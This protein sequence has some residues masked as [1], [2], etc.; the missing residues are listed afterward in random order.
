MCIKLERLFLRLSHLKVGMFASKFFSAQ[1]LEQIPVPTFVLNKWGK[2]L[3][4]NRACEA[5]TGV[6]SRDVVGTREHWRA[7]YAEARPCLADVILNSQN[8]QLDELYAAESIEL[9]SGGELHAENWC[10]LPN[11]KRVYLAISASPVRD[12]FG[13]IVAVVETLRDLTAERE[14]EAAVAEA[15]RLNDA[16]TEEALVLSQLNDWL[17]SCKTLDELCDMVAQF[18]SKL[19]PSCSGSL[20][21]YAHSRDVL[22]NSI[23]WNGNQGAAAMQPDECWGL[24]RGRPYTY[25][26]QKVDFRCQHIGKHEPDH[27]SCIPILAHGDTVG[28][29]HLE[30]GCGHHKTDAV[31]DTI[32]EQRRIASLCAEQISLAIA[33]VRLRDQLRDQSIRDPL[34]DLFNRRYMLETCRREFARA[35]HEGRSVSALSIDID[36]FKRFNDNHGHDAGDTVLRAVAACLKNNFREEDVPSRFGG[37]EFVV[38]L[39]GAS[40]EIALQRAEELRASIANLSVRYLESNLPKITISVGVAAFPHAGDSPQSVLRAADEALY[41]AKSDG[42][43][44]VQ[45]AGTESEVVEAEP[46]SKKRRTNRKAASPTKRTLCEVGA[47]H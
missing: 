15:L 13:R 16:K 12:S 43:N 1:V 20:Y 4:W 27:Y 32:A 29:L 44:R 26:E 47:D 42:R 23:S 31:H 17:Q 28:L 21:I 25:G 38:L 7:L 35:R 14:A 41:Q 34:T 24:R 30:Y 37:E 6:S 5:L 19:L 18:L 39:P 2:V 3:I 40:A 11:G 45:L 10:Q 46:V 22:Q 33:N 8:D 36:N 9:G